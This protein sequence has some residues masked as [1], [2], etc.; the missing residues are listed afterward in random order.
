MTISK[1]IPGTREYLADA[2]SSFKM[3]VYCFK[4]D[5]PICVRRGS[6]GT[7]FYMLSC[8]SW[9]G[10]FPGGFWLSMLSIWFSVIYTRCLRWRRCYLRVIE[11]EVTLRLGRL[12]ITIER[13]KKHV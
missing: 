11:G 8:Q 3:A 10:I 5:H 9:L 13:G 7:F 12:I 2:L 4:V 6:D 1:S